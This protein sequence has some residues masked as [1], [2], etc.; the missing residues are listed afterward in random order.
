MVFKKAKSKTK[1]KKTQV[2]PG[3]R[4][5]IWKLD[6]SGE[7]KDLARLTVAQFRHFLKPVVLITYWGWNELS[8]MTSK[9]RVNTVEKMFNKTAANP[10][11]KYA[12]FFE[13][14]IV[15]HPS[16]RKFPSYLRR[17]AIQ[18]AIGIVS[19]FVTR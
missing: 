7:Q 12:W 13:K 6:L 9:E 17:A 10:S 15:N 14:A 3:I 18:D 8:A 4:S 16:F 1:K 11:P 19:S 2:D 5:D